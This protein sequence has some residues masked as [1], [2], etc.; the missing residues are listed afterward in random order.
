MARSPAPA[1]PD[2]LV[3]SLGDLPVGRVL[4]LA[5]GRHAFTFAESYVELRPRPILSQSLLTPTGQLGQDLRAYAGRLPPFFSNLLPEGPLRDCLADLAGVRATQ[6]FAL[7]AALGA[8]LPGAVVVAPADPFFE[9]ESAVVPQAVRTSRTNGGRLLRFSLAGMQLKFS[10]LQ[11][12]GGGMSVPAGGVGGDWILKLPSP[13]FDAL[14]ENEFAVMSLAARI[15]IPVPEV[16]LVRIEDV[17]GLPTGMAETGGSALAVRR[18]DREAGGRRIHMEDFVQVFG[19]FPEAKYDGRTYANV[20]A[21]VAAAA[22]Q[23]AAHDFARRL[24]FSVITGNGDMHLK[25]WSLLYQDP[26]RPILSPA[27]D[28]LCTRVY[29]PRDRLALRFGDS[30]RLIGVTADRMRGFAHDARL[31]VA[32]LLRLA[33]EVAERTRDAWRDLEERG[34]LPAPIERTIDRTIGMLAEATLASAGAG[35]G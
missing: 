6:E 18:F 26:L 12:K 15:G 31:P 8:D 32:P 11:R 20:A 22:G 24:V 33:G 5:G 27:Y 1:L 7:L 21:V 16:R 17:S 19:V 13:S 35:T 14:P 23:E 28:L 4:R 29:L 2:A 10:A 30:N 34:A 9:R 25:N 3:V